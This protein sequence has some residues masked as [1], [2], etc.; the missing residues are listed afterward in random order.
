MNNLF[1][2]ASSVK[3]TFPMD[4]TK[5]TASNLSNSD[6]LKHLEDLEDLEDLID[7]FEKQV[8][9][10]MVIINKLREKFQEFI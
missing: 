3:E 8:E 4:E 5:V 6:V 9:S 2:N 10:L 7:Q 1:H